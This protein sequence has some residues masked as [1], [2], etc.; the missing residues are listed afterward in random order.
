MLCI[1]QQRVFQVFFD[2]YLIF[3]IVHMPETCLLPASTTYGNT[4]LM[5]SLLSYFSSK[6]HI[7]FS[8]P[9]IAVLC[10]D[11]IFFLALQWIYTDLNH[12]TERCAPSTPAPTT[13]ACTKPV[14]MSPLSERNRVLLLCICFNCSIKY[15]HT[16]C[17]MTLPL[18][19]S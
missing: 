13:A 9:V 15:V 8:K 2:I 6:R 3:N 14:I 11:S 19:F 12:T 16:K 4:Q 1:C 18:S 10:S 5:D 17:L 7:V